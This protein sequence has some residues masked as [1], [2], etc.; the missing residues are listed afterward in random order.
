MEPS[1]GSLVELD[2]PS[3]QKCAPCVRPQG[4]TTGVITVRS[5]SSAPTW[6][7]LRL[8]FAGL[9]HRLEFFFERSRRNSERAKSRPVLRG[10]GVDL[11]ELDLIAGEGW[12][13][14]HFREAG[15]RIPEGKGHPHQHR[16]QSC[17]AGNGPQQLLV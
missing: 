10:H 4:R 5:L 8:S 17:A 2:L 12:L 1:R 14:Q 9:E 15:S 7:L 16:P 3:K 6:C 11:H 13:R